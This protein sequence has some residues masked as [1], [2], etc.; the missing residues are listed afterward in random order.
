MAYD[1]SNIDT[2]PPTLTNINYTPDT[3][4]SV[5]VTIILSEPVQVIHGWTGTGTTWQKTY[6]ANM[7]ETIT[8]YDLVGNQ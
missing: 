3:T 7:A 4:T 8:F 5:T 6:T 2:T 1:I